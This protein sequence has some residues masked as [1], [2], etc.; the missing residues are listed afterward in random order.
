MISSVTDL[1]ERFEALSKSLDD[2]IKGGDGKRHIVLCGGTGCLSAHSTEIMERFNALLKEKGIDYVLAAARR[3]TSEDT[4]F[5]ICGQCDDP[6]YYEVLQNEPTVEYHGLQKDLLPLYQK[7]SCY[8][9]PS[10]YPE[11]MSNVLLEAASCGRPVIATDRPG[12]REIVEDGVTGYVVPVKDEKAVLDA[13]GRF[14]DLSREERQRMG[15]MGRKKMER[16][17]DRRIVVQ[18]YMEEIGNK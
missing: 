1:N 5:D 4:I 9:Y 17:F 11:G 13:V 2:K 3:Y 7:C 15:A 14:L 12:C 16:E 6:A 18:R 10:Y 8:L